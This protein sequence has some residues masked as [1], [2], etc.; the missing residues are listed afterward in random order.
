[1]RCLIV[2]LATGL[3]YFPMSSSLYAKAPDAK[4]L[5]YQQFAELASMFDSVGV[6][7]ATMNYQSMYLERSAPWRAKKLL[8]L[9]LTDP[10]LRKAALRFVGIAELYYTSV[11]YLDKT[12]W[13]PEEMG[14][15]ITRLTTT[16]EKDKDNDFPIHTVVD[17]FKKSKN[18][19][20]NN[21][22]IGGTLARLALQEASVQLELQA[23][24]WHSR[25]WADVLAKVKPDGGTE[26]KAFPLRLGD[27][28]IRNVSGKVQTNIT[29]AIKTNSSSDLPADASTY[30]VFLDQ[31]ES[32]EQIDFP[33]FLIN[34]LWNER[35]RA[36]SEKKVCYKCS[37]WSDQCQFED[38][39]F[40]FKQV[41]KV[42]GTYGAFP[43]DGFGGKY[44]ATAPWVSPPVRSQPF[45]GAGIWIGQYNETN[46]P[47]KLYFAHIAGSRYQA[48]YGGG[49]PGVDKSPILRL[50]GHVRDQK[51]EMD[52]VAFKSDDPDGPSYWGKIK[53]DKLELSY[54]KNHAQEGTIS[55]H[56][57]KNER[58]GKGTLR[59]LNN[60]PLPPGA[61]AWIEIDGKRAS[62]WKVGQ[63]ESGLLLEPGTYRVTVYSIFNKV[64]K[65]CYDKEVKINP[66]PPTN[67]PV[68]LV[69]GKS[70][71]DR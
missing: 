24:F 43:S 33:F 35:K 7:R 20:N 27:F 21:S 2:V 22:V 68:D 56:F 9:K 28:W 62:N 52:T 10:V 1:M 26:N 46:E 15:S 18:S 36:Y 63:K 5:E 69:T 61:E 4:T 30:V 54:G 55:L 70:R 38:V 14:E 53:D 57:L 16:L 58:A 12:N 66:G 67:I 17:Q 6:G 45:G 25:M 49:Q 19:K 47:V 64:K 3:L 34:Q 37:I 48:F 41:P 71:T 60:I 23:R 42:M 29:I 11:Q 32:G 65:T 44:D 39:S 50:E 31:F 13:T 59:L 40:D 51:I 8:S